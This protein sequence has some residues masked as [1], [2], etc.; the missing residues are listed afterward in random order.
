[1]S[2][3]ELFE[4]YAQVMDTLDHKVRIFHEEFK[5]HLNCR[6]GCSSC[7][8]NI[9]F[10]IRHIE[11]SY[12]LQGYEQLPDEAKLKILNNLKYPSESEQHHC[13]ALVDG[14]CSLYE[15]RPAVCRA[16][17]IIIELGD[18]LA[19]CPLNF[20]ETIPG[21]PLK[22]LDLVP[23]YDLLDEL[24]NRLWN[25]ERTVQTAEPANSSL[26]AP[27]VSIRQFLAASLLNL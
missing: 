9:H 14:A 27:R 13:P 23:Y 4:I 3:D 24:S 1:M 5:H 22:K 25:Q 12:L 7:C 26:V 8:Q 6:K 11:A 17:G 21:E 18:E 10:K 2:S 20:T 16:F 19:V 15:H